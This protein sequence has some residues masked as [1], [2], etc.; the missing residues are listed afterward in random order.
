MIIIAAALG[1]LLNVG[2]V[3]VLLSGAAADD[4]WQTGL[5]VTAQFAGGFLISTAAGALLL[6]GG[7]IAAESALAALASS[8]VAWALGGAALAAWGV[9]FNEADA[10]TSRSW[11]SDAFPILAGCAWFSGSCALFLIAHSLLRPLRLQTLRTILSTLLAI[12]TA[13]AL[14]LSSVTPTIPLLGAAVVLVVASFQLGTRP[15]R[16]KR[17]T[18]HRQAL[19]QGQRTR[20][21]TVAAIA[22]VLGFGCAAF[23]LIGSTWLP[24]VGD[25]TDAMRVGILSG[26]VIAIITVIAGAVVLVSRRG[27]VALAPATAAIGALICVAVSYSLSIDHAVG[28]PLLI[29]AAALTGLTG[30][31]LLAPA[32]PGPALLRAS[33]VTAVSVA[34]AAALGL[35]VITAISF[36][37]PF[38]AVILA[39]SMARR[40][41]G[42]KVI[43]N[44]A[45]PL[46]KE[47]LEQASP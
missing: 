22:A 38:L 2:P 47:G 45:G 28:W 30:G 40:P 31:L 23:A 17:V 43:R 8:A 18:Y 19:N 6:R 35:I 44:V 37:A 41:R 27:R 14:G 32:L 25:G 29:P 42:I 34:L 39:V 12:P 15:T 26:A 36:I 4:P 10:G 33:L 20:I 16:A 13:L 46:G 3:I 5:R 24:A 7:R 21:A 1:L 11:F 9:G